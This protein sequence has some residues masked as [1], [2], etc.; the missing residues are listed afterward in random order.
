MTD[1]RTLPE[2]FALTIELP[3]GI[4]RAEHHDGAWKLAAGASPI[5]TGRGADELRR[6]LAEAVCAAV[7]PPLGTSQPSEPV[8]VNVSSDLD[9]QSTAALL[10]WWEQAFDIERHF[11]VINK[12][13]CVLTVFGIPAPDYWEWPRV[14][15]LDWEINEGRSPAASS[16]RILI[17]EWCGHEA[18]YDGDYG[19]AAEDSPDYD[20]RWADIDQMR[21]DPDE[22]STEFTDTRKRNSGRKGK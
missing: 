8:A 14:A 20:D 6:S 15:W 12:T 22:W 21:S 2:D 5:A 19:W 1:K 13:R 3:V 10:D 4:V 7:G 18:L 16:G 9:T 11:P 17:H